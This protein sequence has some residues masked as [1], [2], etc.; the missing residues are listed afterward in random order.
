[1][2]PLS[3]QARAFVCEQLAPGGRVLGVR[4]LKGGISCS[5][6]ALR[7]ERPDGTTTEVVVRRMDPAWGPSANAIAEREFRLLEVLARHNFPSPRP[8]LLDR[9][10]ERLEAPG[11]IITRLPGRGVLLPRN[12]PSFVDQLA[13]TMVQL[14]TLPTDELGFLPPQRDSVD[15]VIARGPDNDEPFHLEVWAAVRELWPNIKAAGRKDLLHGDYWP[16]N[17]VWHRDRLSG[18]V[19]WEE[20]KLGHSIRDLATCRCDMSVL[21]GAEAAAR[22]TAAYPGDKSELPFWDLYVSTGAL[23]YMHEWVRGYNDL[24][25]VDLDAQMARER[26][27]NFAAAALQRIG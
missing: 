12:V 24:G 18:V 27:K 15:A 5:V 22:L 1:M 16:G 10:G 11:M 7:V 20:T 9:S 26:V 8:L 3:R 6:H 13:A 21:L 4:A 19:D 25:R 23:R 14:H 17:V 2:R